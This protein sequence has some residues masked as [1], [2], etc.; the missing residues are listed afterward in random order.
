MNS[1]QEKDK[2]YVAV[3]CIIF[4]FEEGKLKLLVFNRKLNPFKDSLSLIGSFVKIG[5]SV[6]DASKRILK[7]STGLQ[8]VYMKELKTYSSVDRDPGFRCIS[9]AQYA[10]IRI[11][12]Y[13]K[14]TVKENQAT[15]FDIDIIPKLILDHNLMVSNALKRIEEIARYKPIGFE[16]LPEKFTIPQLQ[17]LY[18][19]IYRKSLDPRNFRKKILS[20]DVIIKLEEKDKSSS[21]KG[22]YLYKFDH[23]KYQKLQESGYNFEI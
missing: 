8:N 5:E 22:A 20:F 4:G 10:L 13:I 17:S 3:D 18:E 7:E 1:Y 12:K 14:N 16:L 23:T 15:W 19:A 9:I 2:F 11:N 6:S 21:K